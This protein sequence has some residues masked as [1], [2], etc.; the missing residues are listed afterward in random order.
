[1]R[2]GE[3]A[4]LTGISV[5]ALRYYEQIRLLPAPRRTEAGYRDYPQEMVERVRFILRAKE[6]GFS[7]R[8]IAAVLVLRDR[9]QTP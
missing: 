6:R 9:G 5:P 2:I 4:K 8:E 7:L 1:M 3:L